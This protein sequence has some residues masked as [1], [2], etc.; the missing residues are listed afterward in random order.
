MAFISSSFSNR[1]LQDRRFTTNQVGDS[2]EAFAS[3][4]S[5]GS[6]EVFT[7]TRYILTSSLP[8]SGSSQDGLIA[9]ASRV[10]DSITPGSADDLAIS[11]YWFQ[12]KLTPGSTAVNS[13]NETFFFLTGSLPSVSEQTIDVSQVTN[14]LSPKFGAASIGLAH[15]E[16]LT[17]V[18][19]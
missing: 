15:A 16:I 13:R 6:N 9:S 4:L 7:D 2:Q 8:F 12:K 18:I 14:F 3:V 5:I 11:K 10:D 1:K 17:L 19:M